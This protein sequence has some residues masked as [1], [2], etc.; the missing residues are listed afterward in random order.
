MYVATKGPNVK[1]G[2]HILN[3]GL[4]PL[5]PPAG[6]DPGLQQGFVTW[7]IYQEVSADVPGHK[8]TFKTKIALKTFGSAVIYFDLER[9]ADT[10]Y[11]RSQC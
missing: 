5:P 2:A 10:K 11:Q 8:V 7:K 3:G 1:W 9:T 6:D 4:A